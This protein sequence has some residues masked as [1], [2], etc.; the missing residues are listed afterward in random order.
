MGR[1]TIDLDKR[2][3]G[4]QVKIFNVHGQLVDSKEFKQTDSANL[5]IEEAVGFYFVEVITSE[6]TRAIFK[7]LKE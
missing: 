7:I 4:L 5:Y 1:M 6:N 3:A 2:Y